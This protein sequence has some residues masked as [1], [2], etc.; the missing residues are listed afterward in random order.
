METPAASARPF[1]T[2]WEAICFDWDGT[3]VARRTADASDIRTRIEQCSAA[4]LHCAIVTGTSI[5]NVTRQLHARPHGAGTLVVASN[6]GSELFALHDDSVIPLYRRVATP[7]EDAALDAAA[8]ATVEALALR[9]LK[10]EIASAR[11][12]RRKI[13][14]IPFPEW[15][16]P[17]KAA[18]PALVAAVSERLRATEVGDLAQAVALATQIAHDAG[19]STP[20]VSSDAKHIE[21]G[22]TDKGDAAEQLA[23]YWWKLGI[24]RDGIL[25]VGDEFGSLGGVPGSDARLIPLGATAFSVG[26]EPGGVPDGVLHLPGGPTRLI[27]LLDAQ[28]GLRS[29]GALPQAPTHAWALHFG[30]IDIESQ[31]RTEALATLSDGVVGVRGVALHGERSGIP[32]VRV[33]NAYCGSGPETTLLAA[34]EP[35]P[36]AI[37]QSNVH[38]VLD[39][40]TG[41]LH[42]QRDDGTVLGVRF[43]ADAAQLV[44][45]DAIPS[46]AVPLHDA[47]TLDAI[48]PG[49]WQARTTADN[50]TIS[51]LAHVAPVTD[52]DIATD[53]TIT[54]TVADATESRLEENAP[55]LMRTSFDIALDTHRRSM[56]YRWDRAAITITGDAELNRAVRFAMF[57]LLQSAPNI[58][59]AVIGA[60]G[61]TGPAYRGHVFWD[62]DV[63]VLPF[64]AATDPQRA[65]AILEYRIA[66]LD[67]ARA[68]AT[69]EG[70]CGVRFPWESAGA[71]TDVTPE[72]VR[73][74]TGAVLPI[75]TG[76]LEVHITADVAWAIHEYLAWSGD[77]AFAHELG[78]P[79]LIE[80]G[81]YWASRIRIDHEHRAHI[82]GV[83]GPDEYH[84]PVDD[85]AFTNVMARNA[86][87]WA[88]EAAERSP[89]HR[90]EPTEIDAWRELADALVDGFDS[91]TGLYEQYSGF[92]RLEPLVIADFAPRRPI[93]AD[94]LLGRSRVA[95][96]QVCKQAD[97]LMMHALVPDDLTRDSLLAN[98]HYYEPRCAHGSSLSPGVHAMLYAQ[99]G[100]S[101]RALALLRIAAAIDLDDLT[102]TT[103]LGLHLGAMGTVWQTMVWGFLGCRP[104]GDSL[105]INPR[106]PEALGSVEAWVTFRGARIRVRAQSDAFTVESDAVAALCVD[107]APV[108]LVPGC[109]KWV[110]RN[111]RWERQ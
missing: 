19:V 99:A 100:D 84:E 89:G 28:L 91:R 62:A 23:A 111:G 85:N 12:N 66:H 51:A 7:A 49:S 109:T 11:L 8:T 96:A 95:H 13:D 21:I 35:A 44:L 40:H 83:I 29:R 24:G 1:S 97:V 108:H 107:D 18:L 59:P 76:A 103:A 61:L 65:R 26:P 87:R 105:R 90:V 34:P 32:A 72:S 45:R 74:R 71:G 14:L 4:A 58:G 69:H 53:R 78:D 27:A 80:I 47:T 36:A 37:L 88:A 68:A 50:I 60:R 20:R 33:R 54:Y 52:N 48:S 64:F 2:R 93:A 106:I 10:C 15:A 17:P 110:S 86:L 79:C 43:L 31:R 30:P 81:R 101:Q 56:A 57:H 67:A 92:F 75:R 104:Y 22:L 16:D 5:D 3:A 73:S 46:P 77:I 42:E 6:R 38:V 55:D 25:V 41:I 39:L 102:Q 63:F 82:F 9:G 70:H 98:L 94:L